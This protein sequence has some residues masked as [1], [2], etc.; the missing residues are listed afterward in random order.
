MRTKDSTMQNPSPAGKGKRRFLAGLLASSL[1]GGVLAVGQGA[2]AHDHGGPGGGDPLRA[3]HHRHG[4]MDP[5]ERRQ[6][7][8]H[9]IDRA[10]TKVDATDAQRAKVKEILGAAMSDVSGLREAHEANRAAM[11]ESLAGETVD[12]D[13][14]ERARRAEMDLADQVSRRFTLALADAAD[15][16]D[17]AQRKALAGLARNFRGPMGHGVAPMSRM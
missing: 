10:L 2:F 8:E 5:A 4:R 7:M 11:V 15:V 1:V 14:L 17:P 6:R 13:R 9:A 12:R 16:L 3:G